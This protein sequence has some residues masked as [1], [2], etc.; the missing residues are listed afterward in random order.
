MKIDKFICNHVGVNTYLVYGDDKITCVIDPGFANDREFET[1]KDYVEKNELSIKRC[2]I[3]HPHP[4]HIVGGGFIVSQY[5]V[6]PELSPLSVE[7]YE[8]FDLWAASIGFV[9]AKSFDVSYSLLD[10]S[11]VDF[12][13]LHFKVIYTPGHAEGSVC[14][15]EESEKVLF[16]GDVLFRSGI[17]RTDLPT[18]DYDTL[19]SYIKNRIFTLPDDVVV[20]P[21]HGDRTT[22]GYEKRSNPFF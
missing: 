3:T 15:Y 12:G 9:D 17:G 4:D 5:N 22:V 19:C 2:L 14:F 11:V 20:Y 6:I 21:G 1:F 13:D 18:G 8:Q 16:S 7:L 10:E